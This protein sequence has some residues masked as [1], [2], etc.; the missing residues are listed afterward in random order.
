MIDAVAV[1][2][3]YE[4]R[5]NNSIGCMKCEQST[6]DALAKV[7]PANS[8]AQIVGLNICDFELHQFLVRS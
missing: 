3:A 1:K 8:L 7:K 6:A 5:E 2:V 4:N